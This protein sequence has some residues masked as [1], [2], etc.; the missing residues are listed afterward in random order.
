MPVHILFLFTV[1]HNALRWLIKAVTES[2][3]TPALKS[4]ELMP[5][6]LWAC[7]PEGATCF[8]ESHGFK[9]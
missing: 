2:I 3:L 1:G 4:L 8:S 6:G 5:V 7:G 9:N